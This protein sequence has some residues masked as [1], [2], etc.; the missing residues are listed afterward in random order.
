M[1]L[2]AAIYVERVIISF[3]A[4][5]WK[6]GVVGCCLDSEMSEEKKTEV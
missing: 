6:G 4:G 3:I 2:A 5:S 1:I